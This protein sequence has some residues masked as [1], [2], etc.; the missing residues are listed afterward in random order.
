MELVWEEDGQEQSI[1]IG[2]DRPEVLLG[3]HQDCDIRVQRPSVSRRHALFTWSSSSGVTVTDQGSTAGTF[4]DG[5]KVS[6]AR[7]AVGQVVNCGG[8]MVLLDKGKADAA[9]AKPAPRT[10]K[11]SFRDFES[12]GAEKTNSGSPGGGKPAAGGKKD[13]DLDKLFDDPPVR[14]RGGA[15]PEPE[16]RRG[17]RDAAPAPE[18]KKKSGFDANAFFAS[19]DDDDAFGDAP[20]PEPV[21]RRREEP[22]PAPK[23]VAAA[24]AP[25]P[26]GKANLACYL[27]YIDDDGANAEVRVERD[28]EPLLIGR[29]EPAVVKVQNASVSGKHCTVGWQDEEVVVRDVGSSNGTFINGERIRR[30]TLSDGDVLRC[31]RFELRVSFV[32]HKDIAQAEYEEWGDDWD[33]D[34]LDPG[35]PNFHIVYVDNRNQL[36]AVTMGEREKHIAVG[37]R[38]CEINIEKREVEPEHC[39]F[40][41]DDGVL[42]VK[43]LKSDSGTFV[44]DN[45]VEDDESVRNGDIVVVGTCRLR[46]VRGTSDEWEPPPAEKRSEKADVWARH[47]DNRDDDLELL[48][49]DGEVDDGGGRHELSVW[50][51]GEAR[52]EVQSESGKRQATGNLDRDLRK[53][54]YDA[55]LK[56][57]FP[58]AKPVKIRSGEVPAE[59]HMFQERDEAK[60]VLSKKLT[61]RSPAYH[62]V[63]ELLRAIAYELA[64]K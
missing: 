9:P 14:R 63:L 16:P 13:V 1:D 38:G 54:L 32:E 26:S 29:R 47:L 61:Q 51:N 59:L 37:S 10:A 4:I 35:Q 34:E 42:I 21:S 23:P 48:F 22:A 27:L 8:V 60:I 31:G 12:V 43:D 19:G 50:G 56:T 62:E 44:N 30:G 40:E 2:P 36:T 55:I 58:D 33:D 24:P 64:A 39:E 46:V 28:Q 15:A 20:I 17:G 5:N 25:K 45:S 57:G 52:I 3:R 41:W 11:D 18:P 53:I 7:V 6:K 49:I